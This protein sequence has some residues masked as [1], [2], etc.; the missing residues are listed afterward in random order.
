MGA[1]NRK[2]FVKRQPTLTE[3]SMDDDAYQ[4]S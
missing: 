4:S 2:I 3:A 1:E